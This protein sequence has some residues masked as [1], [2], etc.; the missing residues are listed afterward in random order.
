[1]S[2]PRKKNYIN[3]SDL[4]KAIIR[5]QDNLKKNSE[6]R[7]CDYIGAAFLLLAK[8]ISNKLNFSGYTYKDEMQFDAVENCVRALKNFNPDKSNNPFGFFSTCCHNSFIR[9]I[10]K[11]KKEQYIKLKMTQNAFIFHDMGSSDDD[12]VASRVMYENNDQY[13]QEFEA[14]MERK[15][16]KKLP[17]RMKRMKTNGLKKFL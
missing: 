9:R 15:K 8:K 2:K 11:E 7:P 16:Q 10:Q 13:I 17:K 3:N 14:S 4:L 5:H 1:M 12:Q 6:A